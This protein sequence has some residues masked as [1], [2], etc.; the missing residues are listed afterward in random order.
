[1]S[2]RIFTGFAALLAVML[3][4]LFTS[5]SVLAMDARSGDSITIASGEV[6]DDDL[7]IGGATIVIDGTVNGDVWAAGREITINGTVNGG[8]VAV[9]EKININGNVANAARLVGTKININ[10]DVKGDLI[11]FGSNAV[12]SSTAQIGNDIFAGA[13]NLRINGPVGG[14]VRGGASDVTI[15]SSVGGDTELAVDNLTIA[16]AASIQGDLTY[17]SENEADIQ[18]GAQVGG[19]TTHK[20]VEEKEKA[21]EGPLAGIGGKIVG[22]LMIFVA[23]L[24]IVL[25]MPKR[26]ISIADA[27]RNKPWASLGWGAVVLFATPLAAIF[28]CFT[29]IGIPVGLITLA[30]YGVAI[31]L[32]QVFVG[33]FIGR[34]ILGYFVEVQSKAMLVAALASGLFI[35]SLLRLIPFLGFWIGLAIALFGLGALVVS[36]VRSRAE[37]Q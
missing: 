29:V 16:S 10:G 21:K 5:A 37:A 3:L 7:Y 1:M 14:D 36:E 18:S 35:L 31:Y 26:S 30:L 19:T 2:R 24:I 9:A 12:I 20:P 11:V 15:A 32:C 6:V 23:G 13:E 22:F 4:T 17:T 33:L 28:V 25:L 27:I 8:V 34:W